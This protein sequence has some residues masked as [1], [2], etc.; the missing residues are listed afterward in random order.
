MHEAIDP[1]GLT[2]LEIGPGCRRYD[3]SSN[4]GTRAWIVEIDPG[5]QWPF[6][7]QHNDRGEM[8]FV[9]DGHLVEGDEIIPPGTFVRYGPGSAHQPM[10]NTG[11][12]LFG[13]NIDPC[14]PAA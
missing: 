7:D 6:V 3:L 5:H 4:P 14:G 12:R 10:T 1:T 9:L 13:V 2:P 8:V 11:V